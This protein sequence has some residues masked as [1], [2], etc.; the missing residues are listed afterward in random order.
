MEA[1]STGL[2]CALSK[3][4]HGDILVLPAGYGPQLAL[5]GVGYPIGAAHLLRGDRRGGDGCTC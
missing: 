5:V 1:F 3:V 4:L 2:T